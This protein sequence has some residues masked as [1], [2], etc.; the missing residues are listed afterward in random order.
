[1][2]YPICSISDRFMRAFTSLESQDALESIQPPI[3]C[4]FPLGKHG[5]GSRW[6]LTSIECE[7][8]EWMELYT[9]IYI[10][11]YIYVC[12]CVCVC[13]CSPCTPKR[14]EQVRFYLFPF[15]F[16]FIPKPLQYHLPL[17]TLNAWC[18]TSGPPEAFMAYLGIHFMADWVR[19]FSNTPLQWDT[20]LV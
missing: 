12:V 19:T 11:I 1:M 4:M 5:W 9:C 16:H 20:H 18:C 7:G 13:T 2:V 6:P 17:W 10:Y 15:T 14:R 3:Q 8:W